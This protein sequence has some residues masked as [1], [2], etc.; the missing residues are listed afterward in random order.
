MQ[1]AKR[2]VAENAM[3]VKVMK[4]ELIKVV[5]ENAPRISLNTKH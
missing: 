3:D 1:E 2:R 5:F 4:S